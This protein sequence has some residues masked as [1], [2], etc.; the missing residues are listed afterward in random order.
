VQEAWQRI[1]V[2]AGLPE[3]TPELIDATAGLGDALTARSKEQPLPW[4]EALFKRIASSSFCLGNG[5]NGWKASLKW[6]LTPEAAAKTLSGSYDDGAAERPRDKE[7]E[8]REFWE[9]VRKLEERR[10]AE[11]EK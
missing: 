10:R 4:W 9:E 11:A 5:Q 2:P 7:A 3:A 1:C 6:S 8:E